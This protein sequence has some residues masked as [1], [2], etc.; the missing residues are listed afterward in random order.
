[1][2][3]AEGVL[4]VDLVMRELVVGG[5][6]FDQEDKSPVLLLKDLVSPRYITLRIGAPEAMAIL[7]YLQGTPPPRPFTHDLMKTLLESMDCILERVV[8]VDVVE[9]ICYANLWLKL[10]SGKIRKV[11]ARPS[12]SVALALR[13]GSPI[14]IEDELF[15]ELAQ[16]FPDI[17]LQ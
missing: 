4:E 13:T 9:G 14:F 15:E 3:V 7:L 8:L 2:G 1:M 6:A 16:E 17:E 10:P 12:D 11:D 5:I